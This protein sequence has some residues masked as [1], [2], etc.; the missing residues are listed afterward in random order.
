MIHDAVHS[1]ASSKTRLYPPV[2]AIGHRDDA[3][4]RANHDGEDVC[5]GV[6]MVLGVASSLVL[7]EGYGVPVCYWVWAI[8]VGD[9]G[10]WRL[11]RYM[12]CLLHVYVL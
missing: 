1:T 9:S 3:V 8:P 4:V 7:V 10:N 2:H 5:D 6:A 11:C 12:E